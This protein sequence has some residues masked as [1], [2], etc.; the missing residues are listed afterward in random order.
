VGAEMI[1]EQK[2]LGV[3]SNM[4][5]YSCHP[6]I[7]KNWQGEDI[8]EDFLPP[9]EQQYLQIWMPTLEICNAILTTLGTENQ[10]AVVQIMYFFFSH[11]DVME[12]ILRSGHA[13]LSP[14]ALKEL[15]L[16]TSVISRTANNNLVNV[17][18]NPNIVQS[19]RAQL[20]RI[21]KLMLA[22]MHKFILTEDTV[23]R[24]LS[25]STLEKNSFQTSERLLYAMQIAS[26]LL[27]YSRNI[28]ANNDIEHSGVG[29]IF[30]PSLNDPQ[31]HSFQNRSIGYSNEQ[32]T[33]L[34]IVI[35]QLLST[36]NYQ[37]QEKITLDL[38]ERKLKEIPDMNSMD[39]RI[40]IEDNMEMCDLAV[41]KERAFEI[42]SDRLDKKKKEMEYCAFII[43]NSLYLIWTHLDYFML[44][45]IPNPRNATYTHPNSSLSNIDATLPTSSEATWKVS[46]E[47]ISNLKQ[48]L[49]S[50]FND[51]FSKQLLETSQDRS[52]SDRGFVEALL[53][54]IKRLVQFVPVK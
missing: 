29:V 54:K 12:L 49:V 37:H 6:E 19:N 42:L 15:A 23:K 1:L 5:V 40:F 45:A 26:N 44:K 33:S 47:V 38:L 16:L 27:S 51:S 46:T 52:E 11:M 53:R 25:H 22:L 24:L 34:G 32:E 13:D 14:M 3:F 39:L 48:G 30:Y 8:L 10:S 41:K 4:S 36:V 28:V 31:L 50:L 35:Q 2:L 20:Y 43:E 7:S 21:Q 18:E 17:L 9:V